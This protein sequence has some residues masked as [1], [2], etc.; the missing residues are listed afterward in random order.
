[1]YQ[2]IRLKYCKV[3]SVHERFV[4]LSDIFQGTKCIF[5]YCGLHFVSVK[6]V[7]YLRAIKMASFILFHA[8]FIS[9]CT[10]LHQSCLSGGFFVY[11]TMLKFNFV[12]FIREFSS[13]PSIKV[14]LFTHEEELPVSSC[15]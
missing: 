13:S 1:M 12:F 5:F 10:D 9:L 4:C 2:L 11:D 8:Y 7:F 14:Q 3:S 15:V 6:C